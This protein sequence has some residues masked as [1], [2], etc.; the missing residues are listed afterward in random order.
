MKDKALLGLLVVLT[1]LFGFWVAKAQEV[2]VEERWETQ[3][4]SLPVD[5]TGKLQ[6]VVCL[7]LRGENDKPIYVQCFERTIRYE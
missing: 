7:L 1:T 6:S 4:I 5:H 2:I 3:R